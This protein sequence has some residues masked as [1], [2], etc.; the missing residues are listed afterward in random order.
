MLKWSGVDTVY[1]T[2]WSFVTVDMRVC[3]ARR[4]VVG[5]LQQGIEHFSDVGARR[6]A[7]GASVDAGLLPAGEGGS[8]QLPAGV[9]DIGD[10]GRIRA[11]A[12][13][14]IR[15]RVAR[16]GV[17]GSASAAFPGW[18]CVRRNLWLISD[19]NG[20]ACHQHVANEIGHTT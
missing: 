10:V 7:G 15:L 18:V 2:T 8:D 9:G 19:P 3:H 11:S 5:G 12:C 17:P 1:A 4:M 13:R 6:L 14:A 16:D 20:L